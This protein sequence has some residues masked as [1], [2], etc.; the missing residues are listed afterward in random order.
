MVKKREKTEEVIACPECGATHLVRDYA[1]GE[2]V[3]EDCGLVLDEQLIDMGPE[4]RAFD[5]DDSRQGAVHGDW[6]EEQGLL[7]QVHPHAQPRPAVQAE[8]VAA[9]D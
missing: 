9:Q 5:A 2:L 4:W 6:L 8:E 3:C 7:R 1:R